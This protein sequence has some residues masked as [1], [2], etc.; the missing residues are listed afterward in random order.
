MAF[1]GEHAGTRFTHEAAKK[2]Q[3]CL[4]RSRLGLLLAFSTS[5]KA[6]VCSYQN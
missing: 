2:K 4:D 3:V 6:E 1:S 5:M